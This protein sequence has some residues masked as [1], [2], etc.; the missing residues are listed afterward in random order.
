MNH[1]VSLQGQLLFPLSHVASLVAGTGHAGRGAKTCRQHGKQV[2]ATDVLCPE[3]FDTVVSWLSKSSLQELARLSITEAQLKDLALCS[4]G[5]NRRKVQ[6]PWRASWRSADT[7]FENKHGFSREELRRGAPVLS[8]LFL[9]TSTSASRFAP[10]PL[11]P[12]RMPYQIRGFKTKIRQSSEGNSALVM[13]AP[14]LN[15]RFL[16]L[17][18]KKDKD[19]QK[20]ASEAEQNERLKALLSSENLTPEEQQR[21]RVAFAEGYLACDP[22]ARTSTKLRVFN[23]FRDLLGIILILAI[24]FSFMGELSGG[25]FRRVLIGTT[26]EVMPEDIDVTFDDVKGVSACNGSFCLKIQR[27]KRLFHGAYLK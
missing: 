25:P 20:V 4:I 18:V 24:L 17:R 22:K 1:A 5:L 23:I 19:K 8:C 6:S 7:F 12:L 26:N 15:E 14:D 27:K 2:R 10:S 3:S 13:K 21:L 16:G 11:R 9:G